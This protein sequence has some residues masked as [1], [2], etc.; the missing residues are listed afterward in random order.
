VPAFQAWLSQEM[1]AT[2]VRLDDGGWRAVYYVHEHGRAKPARWNIGINERYP[3]V[4]AFDRAAR[5]W[6]AAR[7][8]RSGR[9]ARQWRARLNDIDVAAGFRILVT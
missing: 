7:I 5:D 8:K 6:Q 4:D 9:N 2:T 1:R 3:T